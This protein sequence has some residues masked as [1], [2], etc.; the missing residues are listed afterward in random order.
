[1]PQDPNLYGQRPKKKQKTEMTMSS[2][3]DFTSQLTSLISKP[4]TTTSSS[5]SSP[6]VAPPSSSAG[7]ARPSKSKDAFGGIKIKRKDPPAD[8]DQAEGKLRMKSPTGTEQDKADLALAKRK[9]K[10]K[11]QRYAAMKRGD[12]VAKEGEAAPLVDFDRMWAE[13]HASVGDTDHHRPSSS[14]GSDSEGVEEDYKD[15]EIIE[16]EDEFGRLRRGT[17]AAKLRHERRALRGVLSAAELEGMSARPR[18]PEGLIYGDAVQAGAFRPADPEGMAALAARRDRSAT[19]PDAVHYDAAAEIRTKGTGFYAFSR[20]EAARTDEMRSLAEE[21]AR[22]E[23]VRRERDEKMAVRRREVEDRRREIAERRAKKMAD[24]FLDGLGRDLAAEGEKSGADGG[25]KEE[26]D[27]VA[28][29][30]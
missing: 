3:L 12:Y 8:Q 23:Q 25:V 24:S 5:T 22:T 17:R 16:Y 21:R 4:S 1:M 29:G 2:S 15:T 10:E 30:E 27:R 14:S 13:K 28:S 6:A 19:P 26:E 18:A 11:A 9:L 20:D 7:R